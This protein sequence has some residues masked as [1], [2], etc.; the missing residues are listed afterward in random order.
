MI[1]EAGDTVMTAATQPEISVVVPHYDQL[2]ELDLCL[3]SLERQTL[4]RANLEI[5]VVDNASPC[6]MAA[7]GAAVAGRARLLEETSKGAGPARNR[8]VADARG[9]VLAFIDADCIASPHWLEEGLKGLERYDI[10]GGRV[11]VAVVDETRMSGP[12]AFERVFA[13]DFRTYIEHKGF[14]GSGNLF[15]RRAVFDDVGGFRQAVS[16]DRDWSFRATAKGYRIGYH[17]AAAIAHPARADW[18]ELKRKWQRLNRETL[19]LAADRPLGQWRFLARSYLLPVSIL[20]HGWRVL[21]SPRLPNME[22]KLRGLATL[23]K[24]RAWRFLD[25]H[26]A[27]LERRIR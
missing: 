24:L 3:A 13:F 15:C 27:M 5:I 22:T 23:A 20:P 1:A 26:R 18:A 19:L 8:G 14:T 2:A 21:R 10:V 12:E 4:P 11:D 9:R 16:E 6:G 7:V 17:D 25:A